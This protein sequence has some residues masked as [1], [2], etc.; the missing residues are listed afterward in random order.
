MRDDLSSEVGRGRRSMFLLALAIGLSLVCATGSTRGGERSSSQDTE[1]LGCYC[2][3]KVGNVDCDYRDEVTIADLSMLIDHLYISRVRLP[4]L[5]EAN[6]DGDPQGVIGL[7]DV[8][9]L[10]D[11]LFITLPELPDCPKPYNNPPNT[12]IVGFIDGLPFINSVA[13]Y[14]PA[15]GVRMRWTAEDRVDHPYDPPSFEFEYRMYGPYPDSLFKHIKD[16]FIVRVFITNDGRMYRFG[17]HERFVVCDTSWLPGGTRQII[18]DTVLV[19]TL[20]GRNAYG[21]LDTLCDVENPGFVNDPSLNRLAYQS[22]DGGD[23]WTHRTADTIYNLFAAYPSDTTWAGNFLFWVRARDSRDS[24][25]YDPTPAFRYLR[26]IEPRHERDI[27]IVDFV[28]PAAENA[29][30]RNSIRAFWQTFVPNWAAETSHDGVIFDVSQDVHNEQDYGYYSLL[31]G[32][33]NDLLRYKILIVFQDAV[34]SGAW[35]SQ[36]E[37]YQNVLAALQSGVNVWVAAR[38]PLG[39][40]NIAAHADTLFASAT[41]Q[42]FFGVQKTL[43]SGWAS[44]FYTD[45]DGLPRIEDFVGAYSVDSARWPNLAIDTML[46]RTRYKWEGSINP[47][48]FPFYPYLP[49]I[50]ALPEVDWAEPVAEAEVMYRY[51]SLYGPINPVAPEFSFDGLPVMHRLDRG[52]FRTVHSMFTPLALEPTTAQQMVDSVL[53]WLYDYRDVEMNRPWE[54]VNTAPREFPDLEGRTE[55]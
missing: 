32:F 37:K 21:R 38:I 10:I 43:F 36:G 7:H 11:H 19:D 6:I 50:G 17:P 25:V 1:E 31:R 3:G 45:M 26:V 28:Y 12:G 22:S 48:L 30:K 5:E 47:P 14:S 8:A 13:P 51:K 15:T 46:L 24:M 34:I 54:S 35:S 44:G 29:A 9:L 18:C 52:L 33:L 23:A 4:N 39:T 2:V 16:S 41:Y 42:Y 40:F 20:T 53:S 55:P 49:E 27:L